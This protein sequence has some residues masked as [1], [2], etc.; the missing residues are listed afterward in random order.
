MRSLHEL[1]SGPARATVSEYAAGLRALEVQGIA[2]VHGGVEPSPPL[3]AGVVLVPWPNRVDG[4]VWELDGRLQQLERNEPELG[5]ANHGLL[6]ET[7]YAVASVDTDALRLEAPIEGRA[8][9]PFRLATAVEYRAVPD[10]V[11]VRHEITNFGDRT[12]PIAVGAHP[13]LRIGNAQSRDLEIRVRASAVLDLDERYIPRGISP[14]GAGSDLRDWTPLD[15]VMRHGCLAAL[16]VSD[17]RVR[18]G[19]RERGGVEVELWADAA[20]AY[21]QLYIT[22]ALPG[23]GAGE[24]A[25]A[26][27]P[28]TA[29]P[30]A[31]RSGIGLT[32]LEPGEQWAGEWG[33]R[34]ASGAPEE[35]D[36]PVN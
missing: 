34:I 22:D 33:I 12:A 11:R 36:R 21:A 24:L 15:D 28:M 6:S 3:S 16:D 13:Y 4:G 23:V 30:N 10:G 20:F 35:V 31:L 25:V 29:P 8:G 27:E 14:V 7:R 5:N 17:G 2:L 9:Y 1:R 26:I 18:H 19:L 32:W